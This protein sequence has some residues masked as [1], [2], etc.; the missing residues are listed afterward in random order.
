M[1]VL[2]PHIWPPSLLLIEDAFMA[3]K[4]LQQPLCNQSY[5]QSIEDWG[6]RE[7][8]GGPGWLVAVW[9]RHTQGGGHKAITMGR[10]HGGK[11]W[12]PIL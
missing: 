8:G 1:S 5:M 2:L 10:A 7:Y 4:R 12:A 3:F 9:L 6:E 11:L